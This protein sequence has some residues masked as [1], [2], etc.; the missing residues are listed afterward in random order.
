M[1][2]HRHIISASTWA[3]LHLLR[4]LISRSSN[5]PGVKWCSSDEEVVWCKCLVIVDVITD[6]SERTTIYDNL[7]FD[8]D[9][10]ECFFGWKLIIYDG[11]HSSLYLLDRWLEYSSRIGDEAG[12][13]YQV[14]PSW[15]SSPVIRSS[16]S[17]FQASD[18]VRSV[19]QTHCLTVASSSAKSSQRHDKGISGQVTC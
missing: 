18:K 11:F 7:C 4:L 10:M 8:K 6:P 19:V 16:L 1:D 2:H 3:I 15:E 5:W 14:I 13:K 17:D 9:C 12:L